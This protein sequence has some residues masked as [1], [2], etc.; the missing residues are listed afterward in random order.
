M[1]IGLTKMKAANG[2]NKWE[3]VYSNHQDDDKHLADARYFLETPARI[4][5]G[6]RDT[7]L[8]RSCSRAL[9]ARAGE[10][11]ALG[12]DDLVMNFAF[13][14]AV[15]PGGVPSL[16]GRAL[17]LYRGAQARLIA[18]DVNG[19][20]ALVQSHRSAQLVTRNTR[21]AQAVARFVDRGL[22]T[23]FRSAVHGGQQ[24]LHGVHDA[25]VVALPANQP[26][27]GGKMLKDQLAVA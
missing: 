1:P 15:M 26:P 27:S 21:E 11:R 9:L 8:L 10:F 12:R 18:G 6:Y 17:S 23:V 3:W 24:E 2:R 4:V 22:M 25:H 13:A 5:D 14:A 19:A 20:A 16:Q 7:D